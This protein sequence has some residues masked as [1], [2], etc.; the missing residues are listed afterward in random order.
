MATSIIL[1]EENIAE[2]IYFIRGE[3]VMLDFYFSLLYKVP[4]KSLKQSVK[5]NIK[6]FPPDFMFELTLSE[7]KIL[8][9]QIVTSSWGGSLYLP[10][11]SGY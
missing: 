8:K 11:I 6:S 1:K 3:K 5:R 4:T 9:S 2:Q 10:L 7:F